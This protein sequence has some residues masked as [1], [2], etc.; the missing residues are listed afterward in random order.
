M[1]RK[2]SL[3]FF[4][5]CILFFFAC[6]SPNSPTDPGPYPDPDPDP[7]PE[8]DTTP[9]ITGFVFPDELGLGTYA[10]GDNT[11]ITFTDDNIS[12]YDINAGEYSFDAES[13][14]AQEFTPNKLNYTFK[15]D[16]DNY[17]N[18]KSDL[19]IEGDFREI[20]G[21]LLLNG[22]SKL[23][24][25]VSQTTDNL[26][27]PKNVA[28]LPPA[29]F[30]EQGSYIGSYQDNSSGASLSS[31]VKIEAGTIS[32]SCPNV[33]SSPHELTRDNI[34]G[35]IVIINEAHIYAGNEKT[36]KY[37]VTFRSDDIKQTLAF[38]PSDSGDFSLSYTTYTGSDGQ[39]TGL[40][41]EIL[42]GCV[43][44]AVSE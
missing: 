36:P 29:T 7:D 40:A 32:I 5:L 17:Y 16:N 24:H 27:T 22:S 21:D 42:I 43:F 8:D 35:G 14:V 37:E 26:T 3:V 2:I 31:T 4:T 33:N 15:K 23:G 12:F 34:V 41:E 44:S 13:L 39:S 18:F 9:K 30:L 25:Y 6:G 19:Y 11:Y 20:E 1:L 10:D 28:V 38:V